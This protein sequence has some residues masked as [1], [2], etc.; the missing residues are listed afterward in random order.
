M[1][2]VA[3]AIRNCTSGKDNLVARYNWAEFAVFLPGIEDKSAFKIAE[4]IRLKVKQL[5][6]PYNL[7]QMGGFPSS[8]ITVSLGVASTI[9]DSESDYATIIDAAEQALYQAKTSGRNQVKMQ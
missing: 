9:P 4:K 1:R 7:P 6:I 3:W 5:A 2:Q 8:V